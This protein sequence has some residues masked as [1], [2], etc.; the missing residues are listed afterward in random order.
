MAK[1]DTA[2]LKDYCD[3]YGVAVRA[4]LITPNATDESFIRKMFGLPEMSE[5]VQRAWEE[6][7]GTRT[8]ITLVPEESQSE[9]NETQEAE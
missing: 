1:I 2:T 5:A 4:G 3:A 6:S 7:G 9:T 8:P